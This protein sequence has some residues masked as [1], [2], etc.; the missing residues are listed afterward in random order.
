MG[1]FDR[2]TKLIFKRVIF[3]GGFRWDGL[4]HRIYET[5]CL[6]I[7]TAGCR[8]K[9]RREKI[10]SALRGLIRFAS[11]AARQAISPPK[12]INAGNDQNLI[13]T[14]KKCGNSL[15]NIPTQRSKNFMPSCPPKF[16]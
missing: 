8:A 15:R 4:I 3:H 6:P 16:A 1:D 14:K 13:L 7:V 10:R 5:A 9:M 11:N 12:N 2:I